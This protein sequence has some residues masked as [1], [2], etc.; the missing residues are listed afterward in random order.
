MYAH[1]KRAVSAATRKSQARARSSPAPDRRAVEDGDR[2]QRRPGELDGERV[3]F[4]HPGLRALLRPGLGPVLDVRSRTEGLSGGG[5][6]E[7]ADGVALEG[8]R[9]LA[10]QR[11]EE[12]EVE[13]VA[14]LGPVQRQRPDGPVVGAEKRHAADPSANAAPPRPDPRA[15]RSC[16]P[17]VFRAPSARQSARSRHTSGTVRHTPVG[18][19]TPWVR[20]LA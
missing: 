15:A 13:R 18:G 3:R 4:G 1:A 17:R 5:E 9:E 8:F 2:R 19:L 6:H 7:A 12:L 11:R 16:L 14:G 10:P 20:P